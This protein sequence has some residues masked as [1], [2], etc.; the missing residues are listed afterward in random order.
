MA[1]LSAVFLWRRFGHWGCRRF[2]QFNMRKETGIARTVGSYTKTNFASSVVPLS[3][4]KS[5]HMLGGLGVFAFSFFTKSAEDEE[6][7]KEDEIIL[8]L[9]KAKLSIM[10]G[11]LEAA[12]KILHKAIRL[13][14]E[15]HNTQA[16]IYTYDMMANVAFLQ[17]HLL[18]A[19]K[20]FKATLSF[21]LAN[22]TK[23]DDNAVIEISLKLASIYAAQNR[24]DLAVQGFEFCTSNL[25]E[26]ITK[27]DALSAEEQDNTRL[28]LGLCLDSYARYQMS[29]SQL[30]GACISYKKAIQIS[31]EVQ[32]LSH[33]QS[34]VLMNDLAT[35]LDLQG[36]HD[37]AYKEMKK[38]LDLVGE[39]GHPQHHAFLVNM[40]GILM[41]QGQHDTAQ[42]FYKEALSLAQKLGDE[43]VMEK[44]Q[45]GLE[46]LEGRRRRNI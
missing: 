41:H 9:K 34:L 46:E 22:G 36:H 7:K 23:E 27:L 21:L 11:E 43:I 30:E 45:E 26:K 42:Q 13:A 10:Q 28:L 14:H 16:I 8:L 20:L 35:V 2:W 40:A 25:E 5:V 17:G 1:A 44:V 12:D 31:C 6:K 39:T 19:E 32:G 37:D 38:V 29:R 33:P 3:C 18:N 24:H 15:S 4:W